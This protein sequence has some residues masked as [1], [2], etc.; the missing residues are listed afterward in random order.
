MNNPVAYVIMC[1]E[2]VKKLLCLLIVI[3]IVNSVVESQFHR[4]RRMRDLRLVLYLFE[5][6]I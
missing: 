2:K 6:R 3:E 1:G 4:K 5:N